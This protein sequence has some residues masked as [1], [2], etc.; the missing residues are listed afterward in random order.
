[1]TPAPQDDEAA[2]AAAF[3]ERVE[4]EWFAARAK[5][6]PPTTPAPAAPDDAEERA[7]RELARRIAANAASFQ[8]EFDR[9]RQ[10]AADGFSRGGR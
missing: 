10:A 3:D 1:M 8:P 7:T 2:R 5:A 4:A 6:Q 9:K